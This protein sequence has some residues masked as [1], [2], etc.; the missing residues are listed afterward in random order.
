MSDPRTLEQRRAD[1]LAK[2]TAPVAD[3]WVA[4][5]AGDEPYLVP[6]TL[7]WHDDR[8]VLATARRSPTARNLMAYRKA[9]VALGGTR[10]V[11]MIDAV[12]DETIE[13]GEAGPVGEAYAA[14]NDWDPREAGEAF[15]F[16]TLRLDRVQAWREQNEIAGRTIMRD[17][18]WLTR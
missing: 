8:L 2:L 18:A 1:V 10:D 7:G 9:R 13:V 3:A 12:L 5:A 14:Q 17:G 6:L 15:V 16:L 4:T 11:V